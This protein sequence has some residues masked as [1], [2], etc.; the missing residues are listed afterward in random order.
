LKKLTFTGMKTAIIS[1]KSDSEEKFL[2]SFFK[3]TGI[4]ARILKRQEMEDAVFGTLINEGMK[5]KT[6]SEE[7]VV[8]ILRKK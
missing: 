4:K 2:R 6:V 3:K 1:I 5:S 7:S 8:K